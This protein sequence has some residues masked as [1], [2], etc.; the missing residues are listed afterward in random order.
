MFPNI[1]EQHRVLLEPHLR[2]VQAHITKLEQQHAPFKTF[3]DAGFTPE[4]TTGLLQFA[5]AFDNNPLGMWLRLGIELQ[6]SG[7]IDGDLDLEQ[8]QAVALGQQGPG[9]IGD[10]E[11]MEFESQDPL[12]ELSQRLDAFEQR[13]QD[14]ETTR[15][16]QTEDQL[17]QR[18][19]VS[20]QETLKE[21]GLEDVSDEELIARIITANGDPDKAVQSLVGFRDSVVKGFTERKSG[22]PNPLEMPKGSPQAPKKPETR[23]GDPFR[24]ATIAAQQALE[25]RNAAAVQE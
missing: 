7:Q 25:A 11:E 2:E 9:D 21:A 6:N 4:Q 13:D 17:L 16:Q 12:A 14:R 10:S 3:A 18:Q 1:P 15:R 23:P 22:E 19:L 24:E 8:V 20:M 5:Q